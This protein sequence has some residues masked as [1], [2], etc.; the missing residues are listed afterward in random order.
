L[1]PTVI[2]QNSERGFPVYLHIESAGESPTWTFGQASDATAFLN[3][4][5]ALYFIEKHGLTDCQVGPQ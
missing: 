3:P 2:F 1:E 4:N 5:E